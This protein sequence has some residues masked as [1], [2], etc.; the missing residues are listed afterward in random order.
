M[1]WSELAARRGD[2][3]PDAWYA[4]AGEPTRRRY[5]LAVCGTCTVAQQCLAAALARDDPWGI[6]G[7]LTPERRLR[8]T[9]SGAA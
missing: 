9:V 5:A 8:L 6:W 1:T 7:G 4:L 2:P 3:D